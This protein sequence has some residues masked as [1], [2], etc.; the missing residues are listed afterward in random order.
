MRRIQNDVY[1]TIIKEWNDDHCLEVESAPVYSSITNIFYHYTTYETFLNIVVGEE[2]WLS[3]VSFSNDSEEYYVGKKIVERLFS[4]GRNFSK[5]DFYMLCLCEKDNLLSQWR[6]YAREGVSVQM[7]F[8][9]NSVFS[10]VKNRRNRDDHDVLNRLVFAKPCSV[11]YIDY[12]N[13]EELSREKLLDKHLKNTKTELTFGEIYAQIESE[14]KN[15]N[16]EIPYFSKA[17]NLVPFLKNSYFDD[18]LEA[19]LIFEVKDDD[20]EKYVDLNS[21]DGIARPYIKVKCG[22]THEKELVC[23]YIEIGGL[24]EESLKKKLVQYTDIDIVDGRSDSPDIFIGDGKNQKEIFEVVHKLVAYESTLNP[25]TKVWCDGHWPIRSVTVGPNISQK[26]LKE[27]IDHLCKSIYWTTDVD[28][29]NS[30]IPYREK[31][32]KSKSIKICNYSE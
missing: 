21:S 18:E 28:V 23:D 9:R 32:D 19:R 13:V 10:I 26:L 2:F 31:R 11:F 3:Q 30:N 22:D 20:R 1:K 5:Q 17:K 7:D 14:F 27:S 29:I 15:K 4:Q 25:Q 12:T 16:E 8:S 24:I 6:E